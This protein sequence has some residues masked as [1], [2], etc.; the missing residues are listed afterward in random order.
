M[1]TIRIVEQGWSTGKSVC[2]YDEN[3]MQF[4]RRFCADCRKMLRV[5]DYYIKWHRPAFQS[6]S[7]VYTRCHIDCENPRKYPEKY[8]KEHLG[9]VYQPQGCK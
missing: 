8:L 5:G 6:R 2:L 3:E 7:Y 4:G 1:G 9:T